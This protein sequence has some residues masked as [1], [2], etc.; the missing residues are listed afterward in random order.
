MRKWILLLMLGVLFAFPVRAIAQEGIT[1][2]SVEINLWPE[3]DKAEMLVIDYILLAPDT[4]LPATLNLRLPTQVN[5]PHVVAV[6]TSPELVT[7]QGVE[8]T[9]R[10]DGDWLVVSIQATGPAIQLEYYDPDLKKDGTSRS[11]FYEWLSDYNVQNLSFMVQQPYD[12]TGFKTS[13]ALQD[14]GIH[15]DQLQYYSSQAVAVPAG[16]SLSIE[17]NYEKPSDTLSAS[18]LQVQPVGV[19]ENT[20]GRVSFSN[21]LPYVI[22]GLGVILIVGGIVYYWQSG[23]TSSRRPRRRARANAEHEETGEEV[24]CHQCGAR[25]HGGDRFCRTCGARLRLKEE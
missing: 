20:P 23:R 2:A 7:D 21:S 16:E 8:F 24:Y 14:D 19:D 9:T 3:Y 12:A 11:Y 10:A 18:R 5:A 6:G 17:L 4:P 15:Q 1:I 25:A 22:G 13:P